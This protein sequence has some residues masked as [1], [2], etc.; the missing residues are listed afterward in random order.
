[1]SMTIRDILDHIEVEGMVKVQSWEGSSNYPTIHF[2]G[3]PS[4][5][6]VEAEDS[7]LDEEVTNMFPYMVDIGNAF[8]CG[9]C[10]ELGME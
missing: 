1:M 4:E 10:F 2:E 3:D 7:F 9:I 5:F 6:D 8:V